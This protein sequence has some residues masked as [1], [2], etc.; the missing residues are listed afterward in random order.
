MQRNTGVLLLALVVVALGFLTYFTAEPLIKNIDLGLD[1]RGG[2]HV[3]LEAHETEG[4]EITPDTIEKAVSILRSRVDGIGVREPV[5]YP[6]GENRVVIELAGLDNPEDAVNLIKG[7]AQLE[8][9]DQDGNVL[10]TG[11]NLTDARARMV[12]ETN[13]AEVQIEFDREGTELFAAATEANVGRPLAIVLDNE[14]ISAPV[15]NEPIRGGTAVITGNFTAMEA[16]QLAILLRSGALPVSFSI[17]E[18]RTIGPTLGSDSLEKSI[19]AGIVGII[20]VLIFMLGY[21]RLP[22]LIADL[23]L[24]LYLLIVLGAMYFIGAVLTLPGIAG[25]ILS[26][27]MA[28]DANIIIYE[29]IKEELRH[30][31]T[32]RASIEAGYK[33]AISAILDANITTL[34]TAMVL[35]YFGTGP[36]MGFAVTLSI[37]IISSLIVALTFTRYLLVIFGSITK[38]KKLYGV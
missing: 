25:I 9:W 4:E 37:G 32:L 23:S 33:R 16:E 38:N 8:F 28:V 34:I 29:R 17:M 26:I 10:V 19:R 13:M 24:V 31:K 3:V 18:Q 15:V 7:T 11:R 5:I 14:I 2:L 6:R 12:P 1:L 22:G 20:A 27:G 36:I 21:Y 35:M 30:G